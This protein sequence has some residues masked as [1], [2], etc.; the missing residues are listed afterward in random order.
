MR[1]GGGPEGRLV[2]LPPPVPFLLRSPVLRP[3]PRG[4]AERARVRHQAMLQGTPSLEGGQGFHRAIPPP[5]CLPPRGRAA[6][7]AP[8]GVGSS[9]SC[10]SVPHAPDP[11]PRLP[12]APGAGV[13][14][15]MSPKPSVGSAG[16]PSTCCSCRGGPGPLGTVSLS[17]RPPVCIL[18]PPFRFHPVLFFPFCPHL[19][20][21]PWSPLLPHAENIL[22]LERNAVRA[23]KS[24][25]MRGGAGCGR[26]E[27][28][29]PHS[30]GEGCASRRILGEQ[31]LGHS[32][33]SWPGGRPAGPSEGCRREARPGGVGW[34]VP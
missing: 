34:G 19:P 14:L 9:S 30:R 28:G 31:Q 21:P 20:S 23:I 32:L 26:E 15:G 12:A 7:R 16:R 24:S 2:Q 33:W 29:R 27:R 25:V 5:R 3:G 17:G 11:R 1:G 13:Q 18:H 6:G 4:T 22:I 8:L 10:H